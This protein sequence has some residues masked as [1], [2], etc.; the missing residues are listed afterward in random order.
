MKNVE[1]TTV[2]AVL[3]VFHKTGRTHIPVLDTKEGSKHRLCGIFSSSKVLRLTEF[4][5]SKASKV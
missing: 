4:A 1:I 2:Q 3:D 5:R